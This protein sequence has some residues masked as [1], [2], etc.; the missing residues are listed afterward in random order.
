MNKKFV[1][2]AAAFGAVLIAAPVIADEAPAARPV[3][4]APLERAPV[5]APARAA[6]V[7]Q[8][9]WTGGQVGG[10][11]GV[12]NMAQG[13]AEPGAHLY[14]TAATCVPPFTSYCVETPFAFKGHNTSA[15][16]GGFIGYRAQ[17]GWWVVGAEL[18][19]NYKSGS[20]SAALS[21]ANLFRSESFYGTLKQTGDGSL[22]LRAGV[23]VT[24]W[25]LIYATGG[26]ALGDISGSFSY[27][28]HENPAFFGCGAP[29][30]CAAVTG[31]Q[32]WSDVRAGW[33]AGGGIEYLILPNV[34]L[35][36][37]YRYTDFGFY[38]KYVPL[39]TVNCHPLINC[40]SPSSN[41][42]IDLHP[43]FNA[44]RAG[45]AFNF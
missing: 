44:V 38:Q 19:A 23:L 3:R 36:V 32:S 11:G 2:I 5:Q 26:G 29:G 37:E 18:D 6:P 43:T 33:T 22:R 28:A 31:G 12:T 15:T 27:S 42:V 16:G 45:V 40:S 25:T 10:Q 39:T 13:F 9:N 24:P 35:R 34:T 8:A 41:A 20:S 7:Q 1:G 30:T 17:L 4:H 14:P 21:D